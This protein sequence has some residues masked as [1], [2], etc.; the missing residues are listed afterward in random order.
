M[1]TRTA[2]VVYVLVGRQQVAETETL[3]ETG[4]VLMGVGFC[5]D[6]PATMNK[7]PHMIRRFDG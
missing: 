1:K 7:W 4:G 6:R 2:S 3:E 5:V